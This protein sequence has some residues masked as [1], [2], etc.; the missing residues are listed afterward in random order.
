M[1]LKISCE[2][3]K[4]MSSAAQCS[5]GT[6]EKS[7]ALSTILT[8]SSP[9]SLTIA[10]PPSTSD[11]GMTVSVPS[12]CTITATLPASAAAGMATIV[13]AGAEMEI[14]WFSATSMAAGTST[15]APAAAS[16]ASAGTVIS[17]VVLPEASV[18]STTVVP[19]APSVVEVDSPVFLS[20]TV[21]VVVPSGFVVVVVSVVGAGAG[22]EE[23]IRCTVY[24]SLP[25]AS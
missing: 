19:F 21:V 9:S 14:F 22:V 11:I 1:P 20:V 6:S 13:P 5:A 2:L 3:A 12:A 18:F 4:S 25:T 10:L 15:G 7:F 8:V 24:V 16:A 17:V 23:E